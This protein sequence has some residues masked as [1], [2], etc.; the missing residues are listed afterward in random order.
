MPFRLIIVGSFVFRIG[1]FSYYCLSVH[2]PESQ[3]RVDEYN[4][5]KSPLIS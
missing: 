1:R 4:N 2:L 5:F 3:F